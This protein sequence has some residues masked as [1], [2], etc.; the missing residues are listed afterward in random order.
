MRERRSQAEQHKQ[1]ASPLTVRQGGKKS[2][3]EVKLF[4]G[5]VMRSKKGRELKTVHHRYAIARDSLTIGV[6]ASHGC[7]A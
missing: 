5:K 7:H 6:D 3:G 2:G 1:Q 4:F